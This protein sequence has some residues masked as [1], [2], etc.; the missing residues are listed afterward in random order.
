MISAKLRG[1]LGNQLF[2]VCAALALAARTGQDAVF[3]DA[4]SYGDRP[5][6]WNVFLVRR[7]QHLPPLTLL[8]EKGF[9]YEP[10]SGTNVLLDG[11]FQSYMY[12]ADFDVSQW[13]NLPLFPA[14][15]ATSLHFRRGDY[16]KFPALHPL[17]TLDYY[18]AALAHV[19]PTHVLFFCEEH[20]WADVEPMVAAL[21]AEFTVPFNRAEPMRDVD[22]LALMRSCRS[23][24]VANST[25]SWWGAY[26][27]GSNLV[28]YP[29]KW[30]GG[31][32]T[33]DMFP[34]HWKTF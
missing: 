27:S 16:K 11:Y 32:D 9:R 29:A 30:L 22:H 1:G 4:E 8:Q 15:D 18:R 25:F 26:L 17:L 31:I 7:V 24:V 2:M 6:Y 23:H 19:Q 13:L 3:E 5:S 28:C 14:T 10:L 34:P 20:D 12:F 21:A 33:Q